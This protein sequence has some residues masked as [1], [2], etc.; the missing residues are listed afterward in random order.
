MN[1]AKTDSFNAQKERTSADKRNAGQT[2]AHYFIS[3]ER[4]QKFDLLLHLLNN[5]EQPLL[6]CGPR[7]I[8]KTTVLRKLQ[9]SAPPTW[10]L[11]PMS[12]APAASYQSILTHL[13]KALG[14]EDQEATESAVAA[15]LREAARLKRNLVLLLDDAGSL[16]PGALNAIYMLSRKCSSLRLVLFM[17][18]DELYIKSAS[19]TVAVDG[20][21]Q[22]DL[23]P[24]NEQQCEVYM[25]QMALKPNP[26]VRLDQISPGL[27]REVYQ[28]SHGVPGAIIE[29]FKQ[30]PPQ[31]SVSSSSSTLIILGSL[32]LVVLTLVLVFFLLGDRP[33]R[34]IP[35]SARDSG[36]T[37]AQKARKVLSGH[38]EV[39]PI[40]IGTIGKSPAEEE[41]NVVEQ[42]PLL[43]NSQP[44][45]LPQPV[46]EGR[47]SRDPAI[48][49]NRSLSGE[50]Q[51]AA[52][53][54]SPSDPELS[55]E[56]RSSSGSPIPAGSD[57]PVAASPTVQARGDDPDSTE[58]LAAGDPPVTDSKQGAPDRGPTDQSIEGA[59]AMAPVSRQ[60][61][62]SDIGPGQQVSS[63]GSEPSGGELSLD[64][65]GADWLMAQ[66]PDGYTLQLAAF[67]RLGRL[68]KLI[69]EYPELAGSSA[70]FRSR[71]GKKDW[72]PLLYGVYPNLA[73]ARKAGSQLPIALGKPWPRQIHFVQEDIRAVAD[74]SRR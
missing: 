24:L 47:P 45:P 55:R 46:S 66:N 14:R 8:G 1:T 26:P 67:N 16:M 40:A 23:A 21:H 69:G 15:Q 60:A 31:K 27:V 49:P 62:P 53:S 2:S 42:S 29:F 52:G 56:D 71:K 30:A 7:G 41:K 18:P 34:S 25:R 33:S 39:D 51:T 20:C 48:E 57:Q 12:A 17:R 70:T 44:D 11:C 19:D 65:K 59:T 73:E 50:R 63:A 58:K 37:E 9:E 3:A 54:A 38:P 6:V 4:A 10:T 43:A 74:T 35:A 28:Q 5:L 68:M 22:I 13:Q 64:I 32:I 36:D 61:D 72:Y